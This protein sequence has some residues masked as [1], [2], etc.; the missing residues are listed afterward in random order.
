MSTGRRHARWLDPRTRERVADAV[1]GIE[2]RTSAEIVVAVTST[3]QP[4]R[5]VG[6]LLGAFAA[7]ALLV[8]YV[9]APITF[10]DD[11]LLVAVAASFTVT[12]LLVPRSGWLLRRT[13]S[14]ARRRAT[15]EAAAKVAF[16]DH[17]VTGTRDRTGILIHVSLLEREL[18]VLPDVG[19]AIAELPGWPVAIAALAA[20]LAEPAAPE[21]FI[22]R[23]AALAEPLASRHP[24]LPN[25]IDEL[26]D[27]MVT[28]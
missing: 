6:H 26:G 22:D 3:P 16:V 24:A 11:L 19:I 7:L 21:R 4:Y 14:R 20:A 27:G 1:A 5:D 23:L 8:G 10:Y 28:S 9:Y 18:V 25:D 17:R 15:A 13:T 2:A 12:S